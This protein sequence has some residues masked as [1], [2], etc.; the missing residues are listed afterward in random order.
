MI[1]AR[2]YCAFSL[3]S[4]FNMGKDSNEVYLFDAIL[5]VQYIYWVMCIIYLLIRVTIENTFLTFITFISSVLYLR[6]LRVSIVICH[7]FGIAI[8]LLVLAGNSLCHSSIDILTLTKKY[9]INSNSKIQNST[10]FGKIMFILFSND[11]RLL[12]FTTQS[13]WQINF[14]GQYERQEVS[15]Q[16]T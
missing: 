14:G 12:I 7:I 3:V 16:E 15:S 11:L 5:P 9:I 6:F 1:S 8:S 10:Y 13:Y 4:P 2:I